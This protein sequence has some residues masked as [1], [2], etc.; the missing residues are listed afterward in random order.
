MPPVADAPEVTVNRLAAD[1]WQPVNRV[2][3]IDR[4]LVLDRLHA[5]APDIAATPAATDGPP[6]GVVPTSVDSTWATD[7]GVEYF[8]PA[9]EIARRAPTSAV[10]AV[11]LDRVSGGW[12]LRVVLNLRRHPSLAADRGSPLELD[13]LSLRLYCP[14]EGGEDSLTITDVSE[15]PAVEPDVVRRLVARVPI[16]SPWIDRLRTVP[17]IVLLVTGVPRFSRSDALARELADRKAQGDSTAEDPVTLM[18]TVDPE[19]A[20]M[21]FPTGDPA[22]APVYAQVD[23][24]GGG[25]WVTGPAGVWQAAPVGDQFYALP[26]EYRLAFDAEHAQPAVTVLLLEPAAAPPGQPPAAGAPTVGYRCGSG[27]SSCPGSTRNWSSGCA[28]TSPSRPAS[29]TPSWSSAATRAP[30]S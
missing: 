18:L 22:N 11:F 3:R 27:S 26:T 13:D 19:G 21:F 14:L 24:T 12:S 17:G 20:P 2:L 9:A 25:G 7:A 15:Q 1:Q 4:T 10:P 23:G 8:V 29:C 6:L 16:T 30:T 5:I 28:A